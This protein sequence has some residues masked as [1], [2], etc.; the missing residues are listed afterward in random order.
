MAHGTGEGKVSEG[1]AV[2]EICLGGESHMMKQVVH[3]VVIECW[4]MI[5]EDICCL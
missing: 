4:A 3:S 1:G 5:W 2:P